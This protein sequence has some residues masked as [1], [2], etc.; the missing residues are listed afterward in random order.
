MFKSNFNILQKQILSPI[1][2]G[3]KSV[4]SW[5]TMDVTNRCLGN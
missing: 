2:N 3:S 5:V 4:L 1:L